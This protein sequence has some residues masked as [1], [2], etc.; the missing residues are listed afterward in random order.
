LIQQ[1][2]EGIAQAVN[3]ALVLL[4]WPS[5]IASVRKSS[6][7]SVPTTASGLWPTLS[8]QLVADFGAGFT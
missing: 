6:K 2:R 7:T 4:Y 1:T 3:T 5:A 8:A